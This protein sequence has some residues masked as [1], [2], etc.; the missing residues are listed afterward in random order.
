MMDSWMVILC[1]CGRCKRS[2]CAFSFCNVW[3]KSVQ[4]PPPPKKNN[5][6]SAKHFS[7]CA[8]MKSNNNFQP[9]TACALA[10]V[11]KISLLCQF[12]DS[13]VEDV[14]FFC[15]KKWLVV[16]SSCVRQHLTFHKVWISSH[17]CFALSSNFYCL[18]F[19]CNSRKL[20]DSVS[21][22]L[23]TIWVQQRG[24][25]DKGDHCCCP[26]TPMWHPSRHGHLW[27]LL[28]AWW[29]QCCRG[30]VTMNLEA[31]DLSCPSA[32][33]NACPWVVLISLCAWWM[34]E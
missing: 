23:Q 25:L 26:R 17:H 28:S 6:K 14:T 2:L 10:Q 13:Q 20:V 19:R 5:G 18:G 33:Q 34:I 29:P 27:E 1:R 7:L 9:F 22:K 12:S 16:P 4:L 24:T 32:W 8:T 31:A 11:L 15:W 3:S 21:S 30:G